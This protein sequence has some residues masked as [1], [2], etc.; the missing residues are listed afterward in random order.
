MGLQHDLPAGMTDWV[1]AVGGGAISRLERHPANREAWV[2]DVSRSD[3]SVLEAFLRLEREPRAGNPWSLEKET[4]IVEALA[5]TAVPVPAVYGWNPDL[6]CTLFERVRGRADLDR[7]DDAAQQRAVMEDFIDIVA[8]MHRLDPDE[9]GVSDAMAYQPSTAEECA[10]SEVELIREAWSGFLASYT[11]PLITY[12]VDWL[13][14]FAPRSVAKVVLLQGDTGPVNFMFDGDR[15]T[16]IIDWEWGHLGDPL[17][18]LGNI[19]VREFWNPSGGLTGLFERYERASGIPYDRKTARYYSVQQNVRGMI[20]IHAV[21]QT[22]HPTKPVAWWIAYRYV[23]DRATCEAMAEAMGLALARP[24]LPEH[25][26]APDALADAA[27]HAL[28]HDV[29]PDLSTAFARSRARDVDVLVAC[30]DRRRRLV[31]VVD[32]LEREDLGALLGRR[33][34]AAADGLA[35]LDTAIRDRTLDD[36]LVLPYLARRAYRLEW[37]HA[38][39][40]DTLYPDRVW[41]P[42]D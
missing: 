33:P 1:E 21:T 32:E 15:V 23:G 27:R 14:R 4:R 19:C 26:G 38:P 37:L 40:G 8:A 7:I 17:E 28:Q 41:S 25:A 42:I 39:A 29:V 2:V 31:T 12:C 13:R 5:D 11:E 34:R 18:D 3:G 16:A 10:L 35:L 36:E 20:P 22:A 9:I 6:T 30:M 24:D